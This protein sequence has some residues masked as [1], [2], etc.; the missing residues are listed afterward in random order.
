MTPGPDAW[1][2]RPETFLK[3]PDDSTRVA[4]VENDRFIGR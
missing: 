3:L 4:Q 1:A 2:P